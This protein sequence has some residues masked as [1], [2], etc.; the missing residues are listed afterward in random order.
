MYLNIYKEGGLLK[1]TATL[2]AS[3]EIWRG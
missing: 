3:K 2:L 1:T